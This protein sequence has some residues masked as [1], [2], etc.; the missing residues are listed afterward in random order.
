MHTFRDPALGQG[1]SLVWQQGITL[2]SMMF[3]C[4]IDKEKK[5]KISSFCHKRPWRT[6]F[7]GRRTELM[8]HRDNSF[9]TGET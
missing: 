3:M 9:S 5:K 6:L 1:Q 4:F 7:G 8:Y 2:T